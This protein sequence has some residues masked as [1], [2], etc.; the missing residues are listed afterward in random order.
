MSNY[1]RWYVPGGIGF[2]TLAT[3]GRRPIFACEDARRILGEA[4]R[5]I[6]DE[7]PYETIAMVLL[8]DHLHAVW[9]LPNGD[10]DY[11]TRWKRIKREFT[12]NW[13]DSGGVEAKTTAAQERRGS[14]GVW[15]KR[16]YEH[17][18]DSEEELERECDYIHYNPVKHGYVSAPAE[19]PYSTFHRFVAAGEYGPDWGR[20]HLDIELEFDCE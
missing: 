10:D 20:T 6:R 1:R 7:L 8:H 5:S 14:R 9:K 17:Q 12:V 15:Q 13:L 16:F 4:F 18:V 11:S 3:Y 19:W 2:F